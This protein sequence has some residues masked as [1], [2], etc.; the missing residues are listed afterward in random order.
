MTKRQQKGLPEKCRRPGRVP[1]YG[2]N[3]VIGSH[4]TSVTAGPT[5]IVGRK[6]SVGEI[7]FS[8]KPCWPIDTTYCVQTFGPYEPTF[9]VHLLR[10]RKLAQ[11]ES[12]TAIPGLS[13]NDAYTREAL[14]PPVTEQRRI[15]EKVEALLARVHAARDHFAKVPAIV[16]RLRHS[17]LSAACS[18]RLT[19]GW[20][21]KNGIASSIDEAWTSSSVD[22][23]CESVVDCPHSTPKWTERGEVCLRTINFSVRGLDLSELRYVSRH[24][25][26]QRTARLEPRAGDVVHSR[27]GG[28][29]GIACA[30]PKGALDVEVMTPHYRGAHAAAKSGSGFTLYWSNRGGGGGRSGGRTP[31]IIEEL[32]R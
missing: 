27:E 1:V 29:L 26:E 2:S 11:H 30:I 14:V 5:I 9:L 31:S 19:E 16:K 12:S 8:S 13:R 28:I 23:V 22:S 25:Y 32:L 10:W 20:R 17:V 7:H 6:G 3:G 21:E 15:V 24:T 18:G 4:D